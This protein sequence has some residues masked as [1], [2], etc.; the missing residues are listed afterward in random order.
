MCWVPLR[1]HCILPKA[2]ATVRPFKKGDNGDSICAYVTQCKS[3]IS[4]LD[5]ETG[6]EGVRIRWEADMAATLY[7]Q[8]G[9]FIPLLLAHQP[10]LG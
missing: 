1:C 10:V 7:H 9:K 2:L 3:G 5:A 8:H 6:Q 4:R